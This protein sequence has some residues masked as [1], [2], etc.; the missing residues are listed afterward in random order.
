MPNIVRRPRHHRTVRL[1]DRNQDLT[2]QPG[3]RLAYK[4]R[5]RIFTLSDFLYWSPGAIATTMGLPRTTVQSVL[6]SGAETPQKQTGRKPAI[7]DKIRE[8]LVARATLDAAHRRM[9]YKEIARLESV[10]AGPKA[11]MAAF[12]MESY[13]RRV[14]TAKPLLTEAQKQVRLAWATEHLSWEPEHW[15]RVVW[16]D[17]SSFS[18]EGFGRV[19][20]TRRLEEKYEQSCCVL[21]FRSYS[22]WTIYGSILAFG[23]GPMVA[24]EEEGGRLTGNIYRERVLPWVYHFMDWVAQHPENRSRH[25]ILMED[26]ASPHTAKLT[27]QLHDLSGID[28]MYWPANSPDLN[29]IENVWRMLKHRVAKKSPRSLAELR[30]CVEKEWAVL[31]LPDFVKYIENMYERCQAVVDAKGGHTKW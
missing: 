23:K 11:L 6:T 12:K 25:S 21:K 20:V 16:T 31:E 18:T 9:A 27:K 17:E 22:S 4:Q 28:K 26:G 2:R 24:I 10:Q 7:T 3:T 13:G 15:A 1:S 30:Q 14:A 29:L 5:C 19:Y 8:R